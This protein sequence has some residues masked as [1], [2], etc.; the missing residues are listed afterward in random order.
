VDVLLVETI[1]DSLNA[2]AALV[3]IRE[4]FDEDGLAAAGK[5]LPVMISAA[6]GQGGETLLSAQ[7]TEAFWNAVR[8]MKPL[9]VGLNCSLGPDRM[10]PFLAELS[11]KADTAISCYPNA[12]LPNPLS[13]TGFDLGPED[14]ARYLRGFAQ[15]GLINIAGGCCGNTPEHIA[16][17]AKA[18]DGMPPRKLSQIEVAA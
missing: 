5:E 14:M 2:K 11:Q 13:P 15:A 4:V 12:G 1:F 16:A 8:H 17:I 6:V 3:G 9:S 18:L 10:Y 7:T